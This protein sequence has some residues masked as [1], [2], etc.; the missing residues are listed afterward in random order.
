MGAGGDVST[1][2]HHQLTLPS[3]EQL[4]R[5]SIDAGRPGP[6][7][8]VTANTHGDETT[9]IGVVHNLVLCLPDLMLRG[10]VHLYPTLNP[11]GLAAGTRTLPADGR[12]LNR[13]FPGKPRGAASDRHAHCI[14][15]AVMAHHPAALLDLHTDTAGAIPYAIV[16]RVLGRV[17]GRGLFGKCLKMAEASGLTVLR[18]FPR[19]RYLRFELDRSLPGAMI[20]GEGI[21]AVTLEIGPR[22]QLDPESVAVATTSALGVL[23]AIGVVNLPASD[24]PTR[25]QG[26]PWRRESG[27]RT[28]H[29]GVLVPRVR[30]GDILARGTPIA[31]VRTVAGEVL[32]ALTARA[33]GF[34][35]ALPERTHV[36]PGVSCATIAV[37]DR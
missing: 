37:R 23:T 17:R 10:S 21:P 5:I 36:V 3:G 8:V 9:G 22:R 13:R 31:E 34:V 24:D 25:Q 7:V 20:N 14:W 16:D 6:S 15:K 26:G 18:E 19:E 32:E 4:C 33:Q 28:N 30:A 27:P 35:V 1:V 29:K 11:E 2:T 12:D